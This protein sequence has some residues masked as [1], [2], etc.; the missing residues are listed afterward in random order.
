MTI[1]DAI[2]AETQFFLTANELAFSH[3]HAPRYELWR[4]YEY[5]DPPVASFYRI[6]GDLSQQLALTPTNYRAAL[7]TTCGHVMSF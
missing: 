2:L 7:E 1:K 6:S 3:A 4:L 5:R